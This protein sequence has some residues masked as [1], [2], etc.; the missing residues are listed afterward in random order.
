MA[1][2]DPFRRYPELRRIPGPPPRFPLGNLSDMSGKSLWELSSGFAREYGPYT[3]IWLVNQPVVFVHDPRAIEH[4]LDSRRDSFYKDEPVSAMRAGTARI[5]AFVA[6]GHVWGPRRRTGPAGHPDFAAWL[7]GSLPSASAYLRKRVARRPPVDGE[8]TF[9]QW[10]YR[11][12]FDLTAWLALG[13]ELGDDDFGCYNR[14]MDVVNF[15][16]STNL[17]VVPPGFGR[18]RARWF[19]RI[20]AI[21]DEN[22]RMP[23]GASLSHLVLAHSHLPTEHRSSEIADIFPGGVY[24]VTAALLQALQL[25]TAHPD[26]LAPLRADLAPLSANPDAS[27]A[28]LLAVPRLEQ[29]LREA[30]RLYPP[31]PAFM[32]R[33][34]AERVE[35][36]DVVV[37]KGVRL[38]LGNFPLHRDPVHWP[39][40][41]AY[42]PDR[43]T[44]EVLAANPFGSDWFFP[45]GRG[46]RACGGQHLALFMLRALLLRLVGDPALDLRVSP[47][48]KHEFYFGCMTP[49]GVEARLHPLRE[50]APAW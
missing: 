33:V 47:P 2:L 49:R 35:I 14:V 42:R 45:F 38:I 5:N 9:D 46:P 44:P 17:P 30:M 27:Y 41:E 32:R 39:E 21:L 37:T 22:D 8:P 29:A 48:K 12:V 31:V 28:E 40:P 1:L 26:V 4:V 20:E 13:R 18:D 7:R 10:I 23:G 11:L 24:S 36:G 19:G 6:N 15:R 16:L 34:K 3:L 43:W 50:G 25:L